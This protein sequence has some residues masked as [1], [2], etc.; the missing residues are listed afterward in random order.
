[1]EGESEEEI[2]PLVLEKSW[3]FVFLFIA[4]LPITKNFGTFFLHPKDALC[5]KLC[6]LSIFVR[7][8]CT[9]VH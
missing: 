2:D 9:P 3:G 7:I 1:M 8:R 5:E 6:V 4:P